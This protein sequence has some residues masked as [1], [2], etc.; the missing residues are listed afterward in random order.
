MSELP[1]IGLSRCLLMELLELP[2][3]NLVHDDGCQRPA[4]NLKYHAAN[5]SKKAGGSDLLTIRD[6]LSQVQK[7]RLEVLN[8]MSLDS[9]WKILMNTWRLFGS[10]VLNEERKVRESNQQ[11]IVVYQSQSLSNLGVGWNRL[12]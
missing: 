7:N 6:R 5:I 10:V 1:T 9:Q 8:E 4:E 12:W 2:V 3:Y 11:L